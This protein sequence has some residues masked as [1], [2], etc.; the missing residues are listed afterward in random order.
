MI[1]SKCREG[2]QLHKLNMTTHLKKSSHWMSE[3]LYISLWAHKAS[4]VLYIS[5][6]AHKVSEELYISLWA[7]NVS[8]TTADWRIAAKFPLGNSRLPTAD[9]EFGTKTFLS[10]S[11]HEAAFVG[12]SFQL[13]WRCQM[14]Y[15]HVS[16][17]TGIYVLTYPRWT[18]LLH[19]VKNVSTIQG[20]IFKNGLPVT[21]SLYIVSVLVKTLPSFYGY[22]KLTFWSTFTS[23]THHD[24]TFEYS[25]FDNFL[26]A[27]LLQ[28][29]QYRLYGDLP[30]CHIIDSAGVYIYQCVTL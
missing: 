9:S 28:L 17:T 30:V 21:S 22:C 19:A 3:E 24:R 25:T 1:C 5:L 11:C 13:R 12:I 29:P 27:V 2:S 14:C 7:H 6:W 10:V 26:Y 23:T 15:H 20:V 8:E 16:D 4:E 18:I